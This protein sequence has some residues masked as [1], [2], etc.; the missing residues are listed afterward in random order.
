[1]ECVNDAWN[2]VQLDYYEKSGLQVEFPLKNTTYTVRGVID[3]PAGQELYLNEIRNDVI[4]DQDN[5][6]REPAFPAEHFVEV[7]AGM[8]VLFGAPP[9]AD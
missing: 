9:Q 2:Q 8:E 1:V 4:A 5:Q 3:Q 7:D 6:H